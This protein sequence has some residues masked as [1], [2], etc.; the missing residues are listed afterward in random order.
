MSSTPSCHP[1]TNHFV[2]SDRQWLSGES[3]SQNLK[4]EN[5]F[6]W[7]CQGLILRPKNSPASWIRPRKV[8]LVQHPPSRWSSRCSEKPFKHGTKAVALPPC[9]SALSSCYPET[10]MAATAGHGRCIHQSSWLVASD[11][12][13]LREATQTQFRAMNIQS[14]LIPSQRTISV[15]SAHLTLT[16]SRSLDL[17]QRRFPHYLPL[18][19]LWQAYTSSQCYPPS[20]HTHTPQP[21]LLDEAYTTAPNPRKP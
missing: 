8:H 2:Y 19:S 1:K 7:R 4:G 12:P 20:G 14:C 21:F 11:R 13:H 5:F 3:F 6:T 9:C 17:K 18:K 10:L 16:A 15:S